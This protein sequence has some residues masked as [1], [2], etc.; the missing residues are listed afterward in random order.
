MERW[1]AEKY[2]GSEFMSDFEIL[3]IRLN[4]VRLCFRTS[5][6]VLTTSIAMVFPYFNEVVAFAGS[7]TFWPLV[8]YFPIEMY[9]VHK[10]IVSWTFKWVLLRIFTIVCLFVSIFALIG[11]IQ[12]LIAK[13]FG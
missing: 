1:Y 10:M 6:V 9:F 12:G 5:Y 3:E 13:R 4:P 7:V 11:S 2:A 8:V